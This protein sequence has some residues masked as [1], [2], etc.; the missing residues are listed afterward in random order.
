MGIEKLPDTNAKIF[1]KHKMSFRSSTL[2][3]RKRM[4]ESKCNLDKNGSQSL[5][6]LA[7]ADPFGTNE[8]TPRKYDSTNESSSSMKIT[9]PSPR[10]LLK[11]EKRFLGFNL[12]KK[13]SQSADFDKIQREDIDSGPGNIYFGNYSA[14]R[15]KMTKMKSFS[16]KNSNAALFESRSPDLTALLCDK[17]K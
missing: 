11:K 2:P 1:I 16:R 6:D 12:A 9:S 14:G 3:S 5:F 13:R 4:K 10:S 7:G 17:S 8:N 15:G